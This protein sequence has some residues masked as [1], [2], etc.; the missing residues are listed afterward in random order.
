MY[1]LTSGKY[2]KLYKRS[3]GSY[4]YNKDGKRVSLR[5]NQKTVKKKPDC[6][7]DL[8]K[9][10]KYEHCVQSVKKK[11]PNVNPWAVCTSSLKKTYC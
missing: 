1:V 11:S 6:V 2:L 3:D 5:S 4:Y 8:R 10:P 9:S 7:S